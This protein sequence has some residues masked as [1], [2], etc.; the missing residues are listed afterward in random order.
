MHYITQI[1]NWISLSLLLPVTILL[2]AAL[3]ASL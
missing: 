1:L 3:A 2:I